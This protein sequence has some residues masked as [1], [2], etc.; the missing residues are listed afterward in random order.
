MTSSNN[1]L[2]CISA[3][4][5]YYLGFQSKIHFC[6]IKRNDKKITKKQCFIIKLPIFTVFALSKVF[7]SYISMK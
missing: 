6:K 5:I 3:H 4:H 2:C 7:Q 1:N